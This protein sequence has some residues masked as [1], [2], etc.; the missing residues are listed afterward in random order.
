MASVAIELRGGRKQM[1]N[2]GRIG[3]VMCVPWLTCQ[4]LVL[5]RGISF[6]CHDN[7]DTQPSSVSIIEGM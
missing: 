6:H 7:P 5:K 1:D 4:M 3:L 2:S